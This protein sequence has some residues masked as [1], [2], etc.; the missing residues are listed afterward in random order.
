MHGQ[1][2]GALVYPKVPGQH[3][4][5]LVAVATGRVGLS[6][7]SL[8]MYMGSGSGKWGGWILRPQ[9]A[10]FG[11][12]SSGRV[13]LSSGLEQCAGAQQLCHWKR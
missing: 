8:T 4:Q 11:H 12:Q 6:K 3:A 9:D 2:V 5:A 7:G 10:T 1:W 13:G